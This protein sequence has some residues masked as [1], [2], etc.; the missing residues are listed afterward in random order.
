MTA[1]IMVTPPYQPFLLP[2]KFGVVFNGEVWCGIADKNPQDIPSN[3]IQ[4]Y[5]ENEDG[6]LTP[7]SQPLEINSGGF[8]VYNGN[9]AKFVTNSNY[10]L[11]VRDSIGAQVWYE[12][13]MESV[14]PNVLSALFEQ[15]KLDVDQK[16][17]DV[18]SRVDALYSA[19]VDTIE[20]LRKKTPTKIGE[21]VYVRSSITPP[22]GTFG[23]FGGGHFASYDN[24]QANEDD[25][26]VFVD[27]P[28][29]TLAWK[30]INF[31]QFDMRFW[32]LIE[33]I[34]SH[35]NAPSITKA[36]DFARS[37]KIKLI[38]PSG[39]IYTSEMVPV[40]DNMGIVGQGPAEQTVFYK[41]TNNAF[42]FKA[43]GNIA[44]TL[45][46]LVGF[47]PKK[48]V[49]GGSITDADAETKRPHLSNVMFRRNG[50]TES[51][52]GSTRPQVGLFI[53]SI[54]GGCISDVTVEGAYIG[55]QGWTA[56]LA[57]IERLFFNNFPGKG[58]VMFS[59][60]SYLSQPVGYK[61]S[62]T[63]LDMRLVGG[64]GYQVGFEMLG[65]Q[66]TSMTCCTV[67]DCRP[68]PGE[69]QAVA[70]KFTNPYCITMDACATEGVAGTQIS[71][72]TGNPPSY[73]CSL[74]VQNFIAIGQQNPVVA[75][76]KFIEIDNAGIGTT[77]VTFIGG[78]LTRNSAL[79]NLIQGTVS[80]S[81]SKAIK[82]GAGGLVLGAV[83][84]GVFADVA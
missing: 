13:S 23:Y 30:R 53:G 8:L 69:T 67:E 68:I 25:G 41:T 34:D 44:F 64:R 20:D 42:A 17:N 11:L 73:K 4:V 81:G 12:P 74:V 38:A 77:N 49:S 71:V 14:N 48:A 16:V 50:L 47:V 32:G 57:T 35:D 33:N 60:S 66:Y 61:T 72:V 26:G 59:L 70:F 1:N 63:S 37:A 75:N 54:A 62:G 28:S 65:Q 52:Y 76:T 21:V 40:Y 78:D 79:P 27:S 22:A 80:G 10:S 18:N 82:I 6:S 55:A 83:S 51:N 39:S 36:T 46:A 24:T 19:S 84:G 3:Q 45:D 7:V 5:L 58:F 2:K 31:T 9:P 56:Y 43:N 15:L 29:T